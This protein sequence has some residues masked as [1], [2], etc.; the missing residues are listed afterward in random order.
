MVDICVL[1]GCDFEMSA[2]GRIECGF[3]SILLDEAVY[4][5]TGPSMPLTFRILATEQRFSVHYDDDDG[6]IAANS[7]RLPKPSFPLFQNDEKPNQFRPALS[8]DHRFYNHQTNL[9]PEPIH[10]CNL[11]G[12]KFV[13]TPFKWFGACVLF[14]HLRFAQLRKMKKKYYKNSNTR[15]LI[16]SSANKM[17]IIEQFPIAMGVCVARASGRRKMVLMHSKKE[18]KRNVI[19]IRCVARTICKCLQPTRVRCLQQPPVPSSIDGHTLVFD[20]AYGHLYKTKAN[21]T[22]WHKISNAWPLVPHII[23]KA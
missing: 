18:K 13:S 14:N 17:K 7:I 2:S 12:N 1:F 5:M 15:E 10:N 20:V 3:D 9:H 22:E 4:I 16:I 23:N 6:R 19:D 21:L 11:Q 8:I